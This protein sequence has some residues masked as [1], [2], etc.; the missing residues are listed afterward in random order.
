MAIISS[1]FQDSTGSEIITDEYKG[2]RCQQKKRIHATSSE[3]K[4]LYSEWG[5]NPRQARL[6]QDFMF[7]VGEMISG[8]FIVTV[9]PESTLLLGG[10]AALF[11]HG[12]YTVKD[13]LWDLWTDHKIEYFELQ[14]IYEKES[15]QLYRSKLN[16][17]LFGRFKSPEI[18]S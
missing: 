4:E 16:N 3:D 12:F 2:E 5:N 18:D 6:I 7:G 10:G 15:K 13:S 14:K 1:F 8:I 9:I 17:W 11:A